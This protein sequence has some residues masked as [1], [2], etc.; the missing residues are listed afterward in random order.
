VPANKANSTDI[1]TIILILFIFFPP[2]WLF[3]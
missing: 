3:E 2:S 1:N